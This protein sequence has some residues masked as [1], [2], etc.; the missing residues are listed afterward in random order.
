VCGDFNRFATFLFWVEVERAAPGPLAW[1]DEVAPPPAV[2]APNTPY[3]ACRRF[4][5]LAEGQEGEVG[6][7][8][9][10]PL[11]QPVPRVPDLL[12]VVVARRGSAVRL[13]GVGNEQV[14]GG[15]PQNL[16]PLP[17]PCNRTPGDRE[18]PPRPEHLGLVTQPLDETAVDF[19]FC[20]GADLSRPEAAVESQSDEDPFERCRMFPED[21]NLGQCE[22]PLLDLGG[23]FG[24]QPFDLDAW[25]EVIG[26]QLPRQVR[27]VQPAQEGT[28]QNQLI[29]A[30]VP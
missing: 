11:H 26:R 5:Q 23:N 13:A 14:V 4:P 7:L 18:E 8:L 27:A 19:R 29:L 12:V 22:G 3:P 21:A 28:N 17:G 16:L 2:A 15:K 25:E 1:G 24:R 10:D 9:P 30:C 6:I 20:Q